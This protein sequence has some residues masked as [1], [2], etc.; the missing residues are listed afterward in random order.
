MRR[1]TGSSASSCRPSHH[2][3]VA[4][5]ENGLLASTTNMISSCRSVV[6]LL[7]TSIGVSGVPIIVWPAST[8]LTPFGVFW[9]N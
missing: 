1:V 8:V 5:D 6:P 3:R 4:G 9:F 7:E 2:S